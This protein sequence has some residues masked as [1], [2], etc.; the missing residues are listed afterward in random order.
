MR[1]ADLWLTS[2]A[3]TLSS[4]TARA[5]GDLDFSIAV[6]V[7]TA[8]E[9]ELRRMEVA[10]GPCVATGGRKRALAGLTR[11]DL[12]ETPRHTAALLTA[13]SGEAAPGALEVVAREGKGVLHV[14]TERFVNA[15]AEAREELVR[16]AAEDQARG[17]RLWDERVEQY[18]QSWR[19]ATTWPRRVESTSHRL[20]RLHWALTARERGHPLYCWHGPSAQTYEVVAQSAP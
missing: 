11:Q 16:L 9:R 18:E 6:V 2:E 5:L 8:P 13:L 17:T 15:M 1:H 14:C 10:I 7:F 3:V 19:T 12:G 20:G 4:W